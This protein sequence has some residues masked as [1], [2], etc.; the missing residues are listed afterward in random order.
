MPTTIK[1]KGSTIAEL[2]AGEIG[3]ISCNDKEMEE[4]IIVIAPESEG[5]TVDTWDGTG[6]VISNFT[7]TDGLFYETSDG[8]IFNITEE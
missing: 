1:Y 6:V 3:T 8:Q 2:G 7:L 5:E 4:D